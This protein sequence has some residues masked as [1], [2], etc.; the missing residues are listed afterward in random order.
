MTRELDTARELAIEAGR[1]IS[2][3]LGRAA[4]VDR[5]SAVDLVTEVD[6]QAEALIKDGL[7]SA[8]PQT[9]IVAEETAGNE[10]PSG[11]Y[12]CVDPLDGTTNFVHGLP[13]CAVSIALV[14]DDGPVVAV[15]HDPCKQETFAATRNGPATLNE[16]PITVSGAESLDEALLV[17]GFPYN[18]RQNLDFYL[19]YF[20]LFLGHAR[21]V[22]RL[23]S[24]A[25]DLCYVA[26]G[27][28]DGFWEWGLHPWD[29]AAGW[30]IAE[31]AGGLVT[32]FSGARHDPWEPQVLATNGRIHQAALEILAEATAAAGNPP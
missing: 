1:L 26:A 29:T 8:F 13:H 12:W 11:P 5:K 31:R 32:D 6:R 22:R 4:M 25:L 17:T 20:R 7:A 19:T 24:A 30:L 23:G 21:D 14:G 3:S 2:A 10:R 16:S 9:P 27:R 15:V 28:F 18:R